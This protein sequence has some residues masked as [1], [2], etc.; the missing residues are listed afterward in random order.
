MM[1]YAKPGDDGLWRFADYSYGRPLA[2]IHP[3][4]TP[5]GNPA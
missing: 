1:G 3:D 4:T 5:A 2:R